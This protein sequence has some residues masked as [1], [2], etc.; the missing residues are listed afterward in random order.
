MHNSEKAAVILAAGEGKRMKTQSA[1]ALCQVLFRPILE[2][3][4]DNCSQ[5]GIEQKNIC[6]VVGKSAQEVC[7]ILPDGVQTA[8]QEQRLGTGHAVMCARDFLQR[9]R[10]EDI[11]VALGDAPFL[12]PELLQS[13]WQEHHAHK[14]AAT[15]ITA[16]VEN[17]HGYGRILREE[18]GTGLLG[19]V[20]ERDASEQQRAIREINSGTYWFDCDAL[21]QALERLSPANAQGEYYLTDTLSVLRSMGCRV[22]AWQAPDPRCVLGANTR[23]ELAGLNETA[24]RLVFDRLYEA[25]VDIP[26]TDGVIIDPRAEIGIQTMILPGTVIKGKTTV[27]AACTIG[28]NSWLEDAVIGDGCTVKATY[29]TRSELK[30]R[31][32]IG[33]FSQVRPDCVIGQDVKIG[34]FVEIKNSVIG[35]GTHAS[36]LTYIGDTDCGERV[37]FGCG[38]AVANYNG[39]QKFRS[40]IGDDCF[41]GCNTNLVS[42]VKLGNGAY[43]AAG[44]TVT[45]DVPGDAIC[46]ARSREVILPQRAKKY[47]KD[48]K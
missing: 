20:E 10:G 16:Q 36:H 8:L 4:L 18:D 43:T 6:V 42:P 14:N 46:V 37:N 28:P 38:V 34:D 17:A 48:K 40:V 35:S 25:G 22:G 13:A 19:I 32:S 27:G 9:H 12:F 24:R 23:G 21:L 31:V 2:W 7:E 26:I 11:L 39:R 33:P 1:K 29:I 41:I 5:A 45:V 44:S 30:E 15:V 47:R 3:V